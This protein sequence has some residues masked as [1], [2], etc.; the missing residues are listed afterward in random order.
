M[1]FK[2]ET[3]KLPGITDGNIELITKDF[4]M[5]MLKDGKQIPFNHWPTGLLIALNHT[6]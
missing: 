2:S 1:D 5:Y 6:C 3:I 4:D